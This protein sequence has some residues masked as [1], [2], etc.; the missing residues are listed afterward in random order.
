MLHD[1][2]YSFADYLCVVFDSDDRIAGIAGFPGCSPLQRIVV[3]RAGRG[4]H[5]PRLASAAYP[6]RYWYQHPFFQGDSQRTCRA[7]GACGQR[8]P[9]WSAGG[10]L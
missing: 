4:A 10:N 5:L 1:F 9:G 3:G 6:S 8:C 2:E 7:M